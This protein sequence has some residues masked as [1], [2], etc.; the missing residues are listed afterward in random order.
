MPALRHLSKPAF[1]VRHLFTPLG[2]RFF[3]KGSEPEEKTRKSWIMMVRYLWRWVSP[4][5]R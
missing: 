5:P 2:T 1:V 4:S 3:R